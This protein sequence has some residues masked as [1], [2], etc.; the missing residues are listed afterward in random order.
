MNPNREANVLCWE[1]K[2]LNF[3]TSI[4]NINESR[5]KIILLLEKNYSF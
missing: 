3:N 1:G 4:H 5:A 2:N